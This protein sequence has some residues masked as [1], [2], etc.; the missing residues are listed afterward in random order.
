MNLQA[1]SDG[2]D[3]S[4]EVRF[5]IEKIATQPGSTEKTAQ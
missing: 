2:E 4:E 3:V 1:V 5:D